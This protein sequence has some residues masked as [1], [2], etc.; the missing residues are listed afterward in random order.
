MTWKSNIELDDIVSL[1]WLA[2]VGTSVFTLTA[3]VAYNIYAGRIAL[4]GTIPIAAV[5]TNLVTP[6]VLFV[7]ALALLDVYGKRRIKTLLD[8]ARGQ[9]LDVSDVRQVRDENTGDDS[10][11]N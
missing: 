9:G 4:S 6:I 1:G 7:T 8:M 2:V 3:A 11:S 10:E 5:F